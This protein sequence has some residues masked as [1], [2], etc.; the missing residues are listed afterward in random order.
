MIQPKI[1]AAWRKL[2][3][4]N[5]GIDPQ[6]LD[7]WLPR[8]TKY[9]LFQNKCYISLVGFL[10]EH[11]RLNK[12]PIPFHTNFDEVNLRFYVKRLHQREWKN[13]VVFLKEIVPLPMVT[14]VANS[15]FK[16]HYVTMPMRHEIKQDPNYLFVKYAWKNERW[17]SFE[18][19]SSSSPYHFSDDSLENFLTFQHWGYTKINEEDTYEYAVEHPRWRA[20]PTQEYKI[21]VDFGEVYGPSFAFLQHQVPDSVFLVEGSDIT[22]EKSQR[23]G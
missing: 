19:K 13:G 14:L 8:H 10:F 5:Y 15:F 17:H 2:L 6:V 12:L 1:T 7:P 22:L 21:D 9:S 16:E 23:I 11:V 3:L 20:Y 4:V 18:I